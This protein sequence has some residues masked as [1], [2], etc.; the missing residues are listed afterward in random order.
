MRGETVDSQLE[1]MEKRLYTL[2][3]SNRK[4]KFGCIVALICATVLVSMG[5]QQATKRTIE[6]NEFILL[7][8][9]GHHRARLSADSLGDASLVFYDD[10]KKIQGIFAADRLV[11]SD[12]HGNARIAIRPDSD[13]GTFIMTGRDGEGLEVSQD[14]DQVG[15]YMTKRSREVL[16]MSIEKNGPAIRLMDEQGF[17]TDLGQ[18]DIGRLPTTSAA[19][20]VMVGKDGGV[21]WSA[22]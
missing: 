8:P 10:S 19:S 17:M 18:T 9:N 16:K 6:A 2:E 14:S 5:A 12:L 21:I 15:L 13:G 20:I 1:I 3:R 11:F 22:P 7:D 4:M